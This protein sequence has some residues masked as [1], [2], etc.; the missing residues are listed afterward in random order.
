MMRLMPDLL[1]ELTFAQSEC[2]FLILSNLGKITVHELRSV[3]SSFAIE[4][5][6]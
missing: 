3:T 2:N 5:L 4:M 6:T 1:F